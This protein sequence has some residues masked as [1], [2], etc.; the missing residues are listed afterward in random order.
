MLILY[1]IVVS[2]MY[3][4]LLKTK[5]CRKRNQTWLLHQFG[6]TS[7]HKN[8]V[9]AGCLWYLF[10][11]NFSAAKSIRISHAWLPAVVYYWYIIITCWRS[12]LSFFCFQN[13]SYPSVCL[14]KALSKNK[15]KSFNF[16]LWFSLKR[17]FFI[18]NLNFH[19]GLVR[20]FSNF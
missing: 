8:P 15:N 13:P 19:I 1:V 4:Q 5:T 18:K 2:L 20:A 17:F 6:P 12:S 10:C 14:Y 11:L 7:M 9:L 3:S 16:S